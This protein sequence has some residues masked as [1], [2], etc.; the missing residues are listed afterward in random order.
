MKRK[1]SLL[2]EL[3]DNYV[4]VCDDDGNY[5]SRQC[6]GF[7]LECW[8]VDKITGEE[9]LGSRG[10]QFNPDYNVDCDNYAGKCI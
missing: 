3:F 2:S 5:Q 8:C 1:E 4:P 10:A 6:Y 9:L 7:L